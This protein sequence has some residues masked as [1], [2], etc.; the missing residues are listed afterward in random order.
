MDHAFPAEGGV[1]LDAFNTGAVAAATGLAECTPRARTAETPFLDPD[2]CFA[3]N[4]PMTDMF[5][6]MGHDFGP[7][8]FHMSRSSMTTLCLILIVFC[9]WVAIHSIYKDTAS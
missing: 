3:E 4:D 6:I 2:A 7:S 1:K 9:W 8:D 5:Q